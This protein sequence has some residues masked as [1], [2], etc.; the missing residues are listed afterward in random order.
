[1]ACIAMSLVKTWRQLKRTPVLTGVTLATFALVF[2]I[3]GML[4]F[5]GHHL[6]ALSERMQQGTEL[7]VFL[8]ESCSLDQREQIQKSLRVAPGVRD[9]RFWEKNEATDRFRK[10]L[11]EHAY[12]LDGLEKDLLPASF[13]VSFSQTAGVDPIRRLAGELSQMKGV[14]SVEYGEGWVDRLV[15]MV[16]SIRTLMAVV[17]GS[18]LFV[19]LLIMANTIRLSIFAQQEEIRILRL[20]GATERFIKTPFFLAGGFLGGLGAGLGGVASWLL[21]LTWIPE[22]ALPGWLLELRWN[23]GFLPGYWLGWMIALG[24][25]VGVLGTWFSLVRTASG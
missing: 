15:P 16:H 8:A 25:L 12:V 21:F 13:E 11:G 10:L 2:F 24:V 4:V 18:I 5:T 9:Q 20:V 17:G 6:V 14:E 7:S 19:G 3:L 22:I 23:V 1:M